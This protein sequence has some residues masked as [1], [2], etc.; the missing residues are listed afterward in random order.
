MSGT[1]HARSLGRK[2]FNMTSLLWNFRLLTGGNP[3]GH[4]KHAEA[5]WSKRSKF[6]TIFKRSSRE[7]LLSEE[8]EV[9]SANLKKTA[10]QPC[11]WHAVP[12]GHVN[13]FCPAILLRSF[14]KLWT[15]SV[16]S[17]QKLVWNISWL[18]RMPWRHS[19]ST[20]WVVSSRKMRVDLQWGKVVFFF[21]ALGHVHRKICSSPTESVG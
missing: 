2:G 4:G 8:L 17:L 9:C 12:R 21:K 11:Q 5:Y 18:I 20:F 1:K 6:K 13:S 7:S 19:V 15:R 3:S 16:R 10:L 14:R